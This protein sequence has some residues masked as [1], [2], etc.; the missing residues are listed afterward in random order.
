MSVKVSSYPDPDL[1]NTTEGTQEGKILKP[2]LLPERYI[3]VS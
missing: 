1:K 3:K 2:G